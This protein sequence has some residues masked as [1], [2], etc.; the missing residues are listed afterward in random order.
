VKPQILLAETTTPDG[1][2]LSLVS[3]DGH[4]HLQS[5][6]DKLMSTFAHHSE[7]A[8]A[9]M[10]CA[11]SRPARQPL[12]LV[13]GL[14]F[15]YTL[16]AATRAL[17]QKGARFL[18]AEQAPAIIEWNQTHLRDLHPGLWDDDRILIEPETVQK[19]MAEHPESFSAILLDVDNGP[20]AFQDASNEALYSPAGLSAARD[21]LKTGGILGVWS[22]RPD[23]TFEKRLYQAG[24]EVTCEKVPAS[25]KGKQNRFHTIWL[26]KKDHY[27]TRPPQ[28]KRR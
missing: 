21:A 4:Y 18:V 2:P 26:A 12:V 27:E 7:E 1:E 19:L 16:A 15:G 22:L 20:W 28:A 10:A 3:H 11:P 6:G 24:F 17:P 5:R 9:E 14:G 13:G 25:N 8:L 23:K